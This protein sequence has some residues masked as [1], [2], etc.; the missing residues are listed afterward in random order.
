MQFF[1]SPF[2]KIGITFSCFKISEKTT[3]EKDK[4]IRPDIGLEEHILISLRIVVVPGLTVLY[5][6]SVLRMSS[7]SSSVV[8]DKKKEF[9]F[10]FFKYDWKDLGVYGI[11]LTRFFPNWYEE[12]IKMVWNS[13]IICYSF[14][15]NTQACIVGRVFVFQVNYWPNALPRFLR[16]FFII[17]KKWLLILFF[18]YPC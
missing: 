5:V 4:L 12:V 10:E 3:D 11:L 14:I 16:I 7:T 13:K 1:W 2:L 18:G 6:F 9:L 8:G 17:L 15:V